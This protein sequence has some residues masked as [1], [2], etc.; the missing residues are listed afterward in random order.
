M[1]RKRNKILMKTLKTVLLVALFISP[2]I[3][4]TAEEDEHAPHQTVLNLKNV[5]IRALISQVADIT[6]YNFIIDPRVK[7]NVTVISTKTMT[8]SEVYQVFLS[9]LKVH[10]FSAIKSGHTIKV[11]PESQGKQTAIPVASDDKP[12]VGKGDEMVTRVMQVQNTTAHQLI[13]ILRPLIPSHGH[14]AAYPPTNVIIISDYAGNIERIVNI[15]KQ[16]DKASDEQH[17]IVSLQHASATEVVK[18]LENLS[19]EKFDQRRQG[20]KATRAVADTR[21]NSIIINGETSARKRMQDL[22]TQL[23]TPQKMSG[24]TAVVYLNYAK[25]ADLAKVL[26]GIKK[27][28]AEQSTDTPAEE[29]KKTGEN[30][31]IQPDEATN[32]LVITAPPDV[33]KNLQD[34]IN[35]L[36][37]RRSQ[38]LVEA[39]IAEVNQSKTRDLGIQWGYQNRNF[40]GSLSADAVGA[41]IGST[42]S[43]TT[44]L[45]DFPNNLLTAIT[46]NADSGLL[47]GGNVDKSGK[48]A[49]NG[50][51]QY[52]ISD[53][54]ANI[55]STP[56]LVTLNNVQAEIVVGEEIPFKTSE[57]LLDGN[58]KTPFNN[59]ERKNVATELKVTPHINAG[60]A[61]TLEIEQKSDSQG[62]AIVGAA[63]IVTNKRTIKTTVLVEDGETIVLGGLTNKQDDEKNQKVPL[64][65]DIPILGHL[66]KSTNNKRKNNTLMIFIR[67]SILRDSDTQ[68]RLSKERYDYLR[69]LQFKKREKGIDFLPDDETPLLPELSKEPSLPPSYE[70]LHGPQPTAAENKG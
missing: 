36:D 61:I 11:V 3:G 4:N 57:Q 40:I 30:I 67:P 44:G 60:G 17:E 41:G 62:T 27:K 24:S 34:V 50:L 21:T 35:R 23:D 7:G 15:I 42:F 48:M 26:E 64:L 66:F 56:T 31:M 38:V 28:L 37:I 25:A 45:L 8:E 53:V 32:S 49:W 6:G 19:G 51:L 5:D 59:I 2:L 43:A 13:P 9:I 29:G 47:A 52:L 65:G 18:L 14:L 54:E 70:S 33:Q 22:I 69:S 16:I 12:S 1:E 20:V 10:G 46:G 58:V 39:I 68:K 55:L 63:D